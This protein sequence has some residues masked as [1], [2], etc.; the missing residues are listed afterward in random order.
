MVELVA[1]TGV[2]PSSIG[3]RASNPAALCSDALVFTRLWWAP[4][5]G[6]RSHTWDPGAP[7]ALRPDP[8]N[9]AN[10]RRTVRPAALHSLTSCSRCELTS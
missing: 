2:G 3:A 5:S 10:S 1:T 8:R 4:S 6:G 7:A 9:S